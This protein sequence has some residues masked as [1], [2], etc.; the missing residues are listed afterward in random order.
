M[1]MLFRVMKPDGSS[2]PI[3]NL[4]DESSTGYS[5]NDVLQSKWCTVEYIQQK[6]IIE[7]L[8]ALGPGAW[9]W[10]K[11]LVDGYY[12]VSVREED[13]AY[14]AF[15]FDG[16]VYAFQVLPM[17]LSS[18]PRIF[19]D[20]M[21]FPIWA[22]RNDRPELYQITAPASTLHHHHFRSDSD[23]QRSGENYII[24][25]IFYYLDD[26]LGGHRT[27]Q[28][29]N[30]QWLHSESILKH[31]L[32]ET[33]MAKGRP[34]AQVQIFLGKE[35][36]TTRQWV[37]LSDEKVAK[38]SQVITDL[39]TKAFVNEKDMLSIVGK[40]RHMASIYRPLSAFARSLEQ[41][42]YHRRHGSDI[43]VS[44]NLRRDLAFA[45]WG[46]N[47]AAK[48]GVPW[49]YFVDSPGTPIVT[50][51]TDASLKEGAG[52]VCS[53]GHFWQHRWS[54]FNLS[55]P[56]S[57]DI[58]WKE[59]VAIYTAIHSIREH[60][61]DR[62]RDQTIT[63]FTDN[64]P[65]KFMLISMTA[66]LCRPDLQCLILGI[67]KLCITQRCHLWIQHIPGTE[68]VIADALSRF[69]PNPFRSHARFRGQ[70]V[71]ALS[72][73]RHASELARPWPVQTRFLVWDDPTD[74]RQANPRI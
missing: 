13:I 6:E 45:R 14:L 21:H 2:R 16:K 33:K 17:G 23:I 48:Y 59:L 18:S 20:Y 73:L 31:F 46:L 29:A 9:L 4:A 10:A 7:I 47:H 60:L 41:Y 1:N 51:F 69:K 3:L 27:Q 30:E 71:N 37:R 58:L 52:A 54:E 67:C 32:M 8:L 35:Y 57:R 24:A 53:T 44:R 36:D 26:I 12:N 42:I 64:E 43:H 5:I 70:Q 19:T 56:E 50:C 68:N 62:L 25:T 22:I 38:Y 28:G 72:F 63:L 40:I 49:R 61:G 34:P 15:S 74:R 66:R 55:Y 11:D 39:L 65:C